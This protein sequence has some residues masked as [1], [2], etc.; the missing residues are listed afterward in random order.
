MVYIGT[1]DKEA[2]GGNGSGRSTPS[3]DVNRTITVKNCDITCTTRTGATFLSAGPAKI[4]GS[5]LKLT[6]NSASGKNIF[7]PAPV[8][9]GDFSAIAGLAKNAEK[10]DKLKYYQEGKLGSY[11]YIY[12]VPGVVELLPTEPTTEPPAETDSVETQPVETKPVETK[13]VETKPVE[14]QPKETQPATQPAPT[15]P[16]EGDEE[17]LPLTTI[18]IIVIAAIVVAAA[19]V[20]VLFLLKKKGIIK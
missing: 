13:P 11:T 9:E 1:T 2:G 4:S 16:A 17:G 6:K 7:V 3:K 20:V 10:L 5:T 18:L 15:E 12:A 19:A 14:T 8:F